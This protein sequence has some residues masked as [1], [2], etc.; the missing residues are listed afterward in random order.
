MATPTDFGGASTTQGSVHPHTEALVP[1]LSW[2]RSG[3][4]MTKLQELGCPPVQLP[5]STDALRAKVR[6][7]LAAERAAE[8]WRPRVD[9]W[10]TG[11]DERFSKELANRGW[12]GMTIPEQHG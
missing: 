9:S 3:S 7:F 6:E 8:A 4:G 12:L 11:W 1:E 5:R 10:L 2:G